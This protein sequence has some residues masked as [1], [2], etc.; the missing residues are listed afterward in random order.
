MIYID[1]MGHLFSDES[2]EEL[3]DFAVNKLGLKPEWNHYSRNFPH[4]DLTTNRKKKQAKDLGAKFDDDTTTNSMI[5]YK[6]VF[7][8]YKEKGPLPYYESKGLVGQKIYRV[9]FKKLSLSR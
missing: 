6:K 2:I 1:T 9:D 7:N 4:F 3:F 5:L 8:L